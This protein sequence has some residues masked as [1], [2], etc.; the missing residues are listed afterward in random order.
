MVNVA[1]YF[2]RNSKVYYHGECLEGVK[3]EWRRPPSWVEM[4]TRERTP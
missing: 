3:R 1:V 2:G 4:D